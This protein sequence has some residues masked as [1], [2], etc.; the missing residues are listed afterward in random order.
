MALMRQFIHVVLLVVVAAAAC[1]RR[2]RAPDPQEMVQ[3]ALHGVLVYPHSLQLGM[4]AGEE[5]AE[6]TLTTPDSIGQ[7]AHWFREV[8]RLNRWELQSDVTGGDGS[9]SITA[10]R[11]KRPLW[12]TLRPN[13]GGPG[14]TY[15]IIGAV[16]V[17]SDSL[18][19]LDSLN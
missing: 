2:R 1:E 18:R 19:L 16:V 9:V 4:A 6:V 17:E 11:G 3:Q 15:T 12:V 14:T 7:V 5:A 13:I 10:Q 8:L